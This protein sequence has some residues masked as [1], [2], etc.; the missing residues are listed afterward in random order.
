VYA[1][2]LMP[3]QTA[4][5]LG[6]ASSRA[7]RSCA[8]AQFSRGRGGKGSEKENSVLTLDTICG[9]MLLNLCRGKP[10][11][12]WELLAPALPVLVRLLS[13]HAD[14]EERVQKKKTRF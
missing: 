2:K 10:P 12:R 14:E 6:A 4:A 11:P 7:A 5:V 1:L 13:S 9:C 3:G 8:A